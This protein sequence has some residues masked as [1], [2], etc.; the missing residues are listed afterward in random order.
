[1]WC[2]GR[3]LGVRI[4]LHAYA[5]SDMGSLG[6]E[7]TTQFS[8]A[9]KQASIPEKGGRSPLLLNFPHPLDAVQSIILAL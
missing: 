8:K 5:Q 9:V 7:L 4:S 1:M 6:I 2:A 3:E